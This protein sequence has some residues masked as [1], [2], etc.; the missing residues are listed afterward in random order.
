MSRVWERLDQEVFD[1]L[2][3]LLFSFSSHSQ[4]HASIVDL[5]DFKFQNFQVASTPM[6][7]TYQNKMVRR[8]NCDTSF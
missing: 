8:L 7:E 4:N 2:Q 6:P 3:H 1:H 5:T